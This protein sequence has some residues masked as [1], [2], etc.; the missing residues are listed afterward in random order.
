MSGHND[1]SCRTRNVAALAVW[2][3]EGGASGRN[4]YGPSNGRRVEV[5]RSWTDFHVFSAQ[6]RRPHRS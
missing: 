2:E 4:F 5:G 1:E 3:N 6:R